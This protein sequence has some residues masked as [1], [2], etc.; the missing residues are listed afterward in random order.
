M[1]CALAYLRNNIAPRVDQFRAWHAQDG[2]LDSDMLLEGV[3]A[4]G[5]AECSDG[6]I[7]I[8]EIG[9]RALNDALAELETA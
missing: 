2:I 8:S 1:R 5:F 4:H 6:R 3:L 9:Q 7:T